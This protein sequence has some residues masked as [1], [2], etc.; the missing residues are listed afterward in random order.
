MRTCCSLLL[1]SLATAA[2]AALPPPPVAAALEA[3]RTD[4]PPGWAFTQTTEAEG[5]TRVERY[6][7]I[8]FEPE[9]WDL[10][11]IDGRPPTESEQ[12]EY[13]KHQALRAGVGRAPNVKEQILPDTAVRISADPEHEIWQF[14]L[15]PAHEEDTWAEHMVARFHLHRATGV[16]D[17]VE[18]V[19]PEPFAP[20]FGV[21]VQEART[22]MRY[23]LPQDERPALLHEIT[24]RI[25]GRAWLVRSLDSDLTVRY[26]DYAWAGKPP[27]P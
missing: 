22:V 19:A 8:G 5:R 1:L 11:S 21:R 10:L 26:S 13:R 9:R 7:A 4:A 17:Q 12:A 14:R 15:Q 6:R 24:V 23:S 2:G 16:I 18:L 3:L 20:M 25:R 27:A